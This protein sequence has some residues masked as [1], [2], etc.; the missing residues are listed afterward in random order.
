MGRRA[1]AAD[2]PGHGFA[3]PFERPI[4]AQLDRFA[5]G[6]VRLYGEGQPVVLAG[7]SL[8]GM[9]ALRA[10]SRDLPLAAVAGLGPGGLAYTRRLEL[11][12]VLARRLDPMLRLFDRLPVPSLVVQR[13]ARRGYRRLTEGAA[14]ESLETQYASHVR[15][16]GDL[17]RLRADLIA[18]DEAVSAEPVRVDEI[19]V[20]VLLI[21]GE[22]DG[23]ADING[24]PLLLDAVLDSR[25]VVV[26]AGYC[27][28]V[29]LPEET[30][31]LLAD[32]PH[33]AQ[34]HQRAYRTSDSESPIR[35]AESSP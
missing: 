26:D 14:N 29:Q 32:R 30:A 21:W 3:S 35:R 15:S 34:R 2:L 23:L 8:G 11:I 10:A 19:R 31:R 24:A 22:R 6:L 16:M 9:L 4:L 28:Q 7:N 5:D 18:L 33:A 17:G 25:L 12:A 20:P 27:P 1:V 13:A